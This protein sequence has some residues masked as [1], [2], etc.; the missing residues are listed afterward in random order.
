MLLEPSVA[1]MTASRAMV[2]RGH[3]IIQMASSLNEIQFSS[4]YDM[5]F[6]AC[7]NCVFVAFLLINSKL[8]WV[9]Q[10]SIL[11]RVIFLSSS[12]NN[13]QEIQ[14]LCSWTFYEQGLV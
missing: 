4:F 13:I 14:L 12:S 5:T 8:S 2:S 6:L 11:Y 9:N 3:F 7:H 10:P 1:E